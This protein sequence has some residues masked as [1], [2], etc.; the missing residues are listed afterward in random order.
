[1]ITAETVSAGILLSRL[2]RAPFVLWLDSDFRDAYAVSQQRLD[3]ETIRISVRPVGRAT[4]ISET[5]TS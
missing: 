5:T 4:M 3:P 2:H 1:V